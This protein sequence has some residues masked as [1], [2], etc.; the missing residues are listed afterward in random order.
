MKQRRIKDNLKL[1]KKK[2]NYK[3]DHNMPDH[4]QQQPCANLLEQTK[5]GVVFSLSP[6]PTLCN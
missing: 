4:R 1:G 6:D 3:F 5:E 2:E